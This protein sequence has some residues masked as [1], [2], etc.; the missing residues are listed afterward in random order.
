MALVN[1]TGFEIGATEMAAIVGSQ[2]AI[3]SDDKSTGGYALKVTASGGATAN[4]Y[5]E[6]RGY[7]ATGAIDTAI[8]ASTL[9]VQFRF[10]VASVGP[11]VNQ[12]IIA[13]HGGGSINKC[14]IRLIFRNIAGWL[15]NFTLALYDT[16]GSLVQTVQGSYG[17][18]Q[19]HL[20]RLKVPTGVASTDWDLTINGISTPSKPAAN[21][22]AGTA[23]AVRAGRLITSG[24]SS[25]ASGLVYYMDDLIIRDDAFPTVSRVVTMRATGQG[26]DLSWTLGAGDT[27]TAAVS[28][29]TPDDD[30]TY[31]TASASASESYQMQDSSAFNIDT[32]QTVLPLI[33]A[34]SSGSY[35]L[36]LRSGAAISTTTAATGSSI[37]YRPCAKVLDTDP[38]TNAAWTTGGLDG[39]QVGIRSLST[40]TFRL[41]A[42]YANVACSI[43]SAAE[44]SRNVLP[45]GVTSE[46]SFGSV[47]IAGG[48][49]PTQTASPNSI[50]SAFESYAHAFQASAT[51]QISSVPSSFGMGAPYIQAILT[52]NSIPDT[53][54]VYTPYFL[55]TGSY[56]SIRVSVYAPHALNTD[57]YPLASVE[58]KALANIFRNSEP[59]S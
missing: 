3:A 41:T 21:F 47:I 36:R 19:W 14:F 1:M 30:T 44:P 12:N 20:V 55:F 27:K 4:H 26:T 6:L 56:G 53:S 50:A 28:D 40:A 58:G 9:Y 57:H 38:N 59:R 18:G 32:I 49:D 2:A 34:K 13:I 45:S 48:A 24:S 51:L 52:V 46:E 33:V 16:N 8:N 17:I 37:N 5:Y 10:K 43:L 23:S 29:T 25:S 15:Y 22:T 39:I 31:V 42:V 7:D 11:G 35:Q 54:L